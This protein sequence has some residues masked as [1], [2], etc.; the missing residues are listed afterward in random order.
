MTRTGRMARRDQLVILRDILR[1]CP[2]S[3][4]R[5]FYA[6]GGGSWPRFHNN[7]FGLALS[8]GL[9]EL[10]PYECVRITE[11]ETPTIYTITEKGAKYITLLNALTDLVGG[12]KDGKHY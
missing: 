1:G 10:L 7:Y 9:I 4:T 3:K 5:L 6:S 8:C 12:E 11:K 2:G